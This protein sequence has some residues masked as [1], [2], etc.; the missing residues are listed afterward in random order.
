MA[1]LR[2]EGLVSLIWLVDK[3]QFFCMVRDGLILDGNKKLCRAL[4]K[5]EHFKPGKDWLIT[6]LMPTNL[7]GWDGMNEHICIQC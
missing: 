1:G 2:K 3:E 5:K 7:M 4:E 6:G